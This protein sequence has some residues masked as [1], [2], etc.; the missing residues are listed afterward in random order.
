MNLRSLFMGLTMAKF[1][2][3]RIRISSAGMPPVLIYRARNSEVE[4][5]L[6]KAMPLGSVSN[7]PYRERELALEDGDVVVLMSD[8]LPERF[9]PNGEMFDY[10]RAKQS[11]A[12][13]ASGSSREIIECFVRAGD[14]WAQGRPQDDDVTFVVLKVKCDRR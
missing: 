9:N 5:V 10:P 2:D 13:A 6:I 14:R 12:E 7:Y 8:G 11:L 3:H 4:E 1:H